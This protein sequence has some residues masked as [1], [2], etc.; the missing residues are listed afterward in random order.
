M[1]GW[2]HR[3]GREV[4]P[5]AVVPAHAGVVPGRRSREQPRTRRDHT[6]SCA[7]TAPWSGT[8]P[9]A[10]GPPSSSPCGAS[11]TGNSPARAGTTGSVRKARHKSGE[12][13]RT[14]GDHGV[15]GG[16][17]GVTAGTAPHARGP[18][19]RGV[20]EFPRSGNS[21]AR[22]GTTPRRS[23]RRRGP[24]E[25]PRTRGDHR[26]PGQVRHGDP[27]TAP[28][29]R[30]PPGQATEGVGLAGNSPARA[31]TTAKPPSKHSRPREQ[32]RTRGDHPAG[33]ESGHAHEGTAPHARG[34]PRRPR[35]RSPGRGEQPRT[36]GDHRS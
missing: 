14:R 8:A 9:H 36:R 6:R 10:R 4:R 21:P 24:G 16:G 33:E 27:G 32:P 18:P 2:S 3:I 5:A 26:A 13:P 11:M 1:R 12:Q 20:C 22:A 31:G 30:G 35:S 25:Q 29:A 17:E 34:P 19:R 15:V 23:R 28:H 7:T